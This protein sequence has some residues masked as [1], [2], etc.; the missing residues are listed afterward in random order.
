M[1]LGTRAFTA[2]LGGTSLRYANFNKAN[3]SGANFREADL[4]FADLR[5]CEVREAD[6][7][8]ALLAGARLP[9]LFEQRA[10]VE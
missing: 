10:R 4:S 7:T 1:I 9:S 8:G 2:Y 6:F 5:G 3:L